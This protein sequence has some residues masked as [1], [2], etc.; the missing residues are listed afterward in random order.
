MSAALWA[1]PADPGAAFAP[2]QSLFWH[3]RDLRVDDNEGLFHAAMAGP[4]DGVFVFDSGILSGLPA[5][6]RRVGFI[7]SCVAELSELYAKRGRRLW[8]LFGDPAAL[9]PA[10]AAR[11]GVKAAFANRDYEPDAIER[12]ARVEAALK[13]NGVSFELYKDQVIFEASEVLTAAGG[14]FRVFTPYKSAWLK[15]Y[16]L[17][18][19]LIRDSA[20][21]LGTGP[22]LASSARPRV[23]P[24]AE[25]GFESGD[26]AALG[27]DDGVSGGRKAVEEFEQKID[28]Y[29][30]E[31]D[32]P[33]KFATSRLGRHLRF[34]T[35]SIRKL[36]QWAKSVGGS[37]GGMWVSEL[38]WREFYSALLSEQPRLARGASYIPALDSIAWNNDPA[39]LAAWKEGRTGYPMVDAAMRELLATGLMHNR[40]RMVTASFLCKD[41]LCD[42]RLGEAHFAR[43]LMDFDLASN[44]GG[45]QWSASTGC[46]AQPYF[47]IFNPALQS[48]RFDP[49]G[50]YIKRWVPELAACPVAKIHEPWKMSPAEQAARGI[51]I[52]VN[53]PA[54]VV[55]R[56][57]SRPL[58]LARYK[59]ALGR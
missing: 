35:V 47:R 16:E 13:A 12:D 36:A 46:D 49:A 51:V 39:L 15:T 11:L 3:R 29:H 52:G 48:A 14:Q 59:A 18:P 53:Y 23:P 40:A 41:L 37:G 17:S 19:P 34:G 50:A 5:N 8:V 54:P 2:A 55:E 43:W 38:I 58:A 27:Y 44:N 4:A 33:A 26:I 25:L 28:L 42:W 9:I 56:A 24:L 21:A 22:V 45:W 10:L 57:V 1:E 32:L 7:H 30:Q 6:D 31:R 20:K